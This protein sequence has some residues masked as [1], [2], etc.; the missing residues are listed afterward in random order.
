VGS[1]THVPGC[2]HAKNAPDTDADPDSDPEERSCARR[3]GSPRQPKAGAQAA[4]RT[5]IELQRAAIERREV[6]GDGQAEATAFTA[7]L[8]VLTAA[9]LTAAPRLASAQQ[10]SGPGA[11][12]KQ[13][14]EIIKTLEGQGY[15]NVHDVDWD[16]GAWECDDNFATGR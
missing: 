1:I 15:T 11:A 12:A 8:A 9:A 5:C 7:M 16:D 6:A 3:N 13:P 2:T 4:E 14:A 10:A